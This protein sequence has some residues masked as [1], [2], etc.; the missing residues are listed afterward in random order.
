MLQR[1]HVAAADKIEKAFAPGSRGALGSVLQAFARFAMACPERV[2]SKSA[3]YTGDGEHAAWNEWTFVLMA[4]YLHSTPSRQTGKPV[5][6]RSISSYISL[7]KGYLSVSYYDFELPE[8][9][10]RLARL[11]NSFASEDPLAGMRK[12]RRALRRRHLRRMW[13]K[14]PEVRASHPNALND[15][16][17]LVTAWH[18]LARGGNLRQR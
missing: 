6:P 15:L 2:L 10:A 8:R 16:A 1:L 3:R 18:V 14:L 13:R 17:L 5:A 11:L 12:K 9:S 7:L 4:V